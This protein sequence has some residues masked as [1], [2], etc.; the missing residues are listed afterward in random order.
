M[1]NEKTKAQLRAEQEKRNTTVRIT[2]IC[3]AVVVVALLAFMILWNAVIRTT[4]SPISIGGEKIGM[5]EYNFYYQ[6]QKNN[7]LNQYGSYASMFGLDVSLPYDSQIQNKET[8][9]TWYDYFRDA[10]DNQLKQ[11]VILSKEA[12]KAGYEMPADDK[13]AV[14][15]FFVDIRE[16]AEE[17]GST[18]KQYLVNAYGKGANEKA[19]KD[20]LTRYYLASGYAQEKLESFTYTDEEIEKEYTDNIDEYQ[21]YDYRTF[22]VKDVMPE[23]GEDEEYTAEQIGAAHAE[24]KAKAE[25]F[26]AAITDEAS[27]NTLAKE[28]AAEA[29]KAT[30]DDPDATLVEGALKGSISD[31]KIAEWL[32]SADRKVG[33][34]YIAEGEDSY[35]I[36]YIS[37]TGHKQTYNVVDV[38][39][40]LVQIDSEA[41][42]KDAEKER[43]NAEAKAILEQWQSGDATADSFAALANEKSEDGGS[44]SNGGLYENVTKGQMVENFEDWCFAEGRKVGDTGIVETDYGYHVMYM[45][46]IGEEYWKYAADNA[47]KNDAYN[48]YYTE[49]ATQYEVKTNDMG[50]TAAKDLVD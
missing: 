41:E 46:S 33:E 32:F 24:S 15:N 49:S 30:Y 43:V 22:T 34:T 29:D 37:A 38:R 21:V 36:Y 7:F 28:Y 50:L 44:N 42:D 25:A 20:I 5:V 17:N 1:A 45:D 6:L 23:K 18:V 48:K 2:S 47:L 4:I 9:A 35:T 40:I 11:M 8:G 19:L 13:E 14:D 39:H 27:F 26:V 3:I 10:A 16:Y 31:E 12:E